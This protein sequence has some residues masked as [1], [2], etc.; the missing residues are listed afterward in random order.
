MVVLY[1]ETRVAAAIGSSKLEGYFIAHT[2]RQSH[3]QM[4]VAEV[5]YVSTCYQFGMPFAV[6]VAIVAAS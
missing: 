4:C 1:D 2:A 6:R 3:R 5:Q